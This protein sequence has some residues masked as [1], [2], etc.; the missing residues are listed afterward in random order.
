MM[1]ILVKIVIAITLSI[2]ISNCG[3]GGSN[4]V[5]DDNITE[6]SQN[7]V[8]DDSSPLEEFDTNQENTA[9]EYNGGAILPSFE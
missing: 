5:T 1:K 7:Q 3:G 6:T 9:E 2:I 4:S 8:N